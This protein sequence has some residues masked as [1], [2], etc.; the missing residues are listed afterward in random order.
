[1]LDHQNYVGNSSVINNAAKQS[2][3]LGYS[4]N[5]FERPTELF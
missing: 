1:L 4:S 5:Q 2:K 3:K